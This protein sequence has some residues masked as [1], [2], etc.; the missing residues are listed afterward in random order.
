MHTFHP[1]G[2]TVLDADRQLSRIWV[3]STRS[4][5]TSEWN[6]GFLCYLLLS[7]GYRYVELTSA[8]NTGLRLGQQLASESSPWRVCPDRRDV[9]VSAFGV[10][11]IRNRYLVQWGLRWN[12][13]KITSL[14]IR[15]WQNIVENVFSAQNTE[16]KVFFLFS[17][18]GKSLENQLKS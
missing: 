7:V 14:I 17:L 2:S 4:A 15:V 6:V 11:E 13:N 18:F 3:K 5:R 16:K 8:L 12:N 1:L 10:V 9:W